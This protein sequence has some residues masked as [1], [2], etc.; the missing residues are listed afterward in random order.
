MLDTMI[1]LPDL[2]HRECHCLYILI[3]LLVAVEKG[4]IKEAYT[5]SNYNRS[6]IVFRDCP[7]FLDV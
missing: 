4:L 7:G 5:Q 6:E 3:L 1:H 2:Y